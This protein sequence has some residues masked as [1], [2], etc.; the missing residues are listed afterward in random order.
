MKRILSTV[1]AVTAAMIVAGIIYS[2]FTPNPKSGPVNWLR[3][4]SAARS[5]A[6]DLQSHGQ[7]VPATVTLQDLMAEG[8]L[9]P[10]DVGGLSGMNAAVSLADETSPFLIR[11]QMQDGSGMSVL[12][13]GSVLAG[14]KVRLASDT[15]IANTMPLDPQQ[16]FK[17]H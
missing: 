7:P 11:V 12:K 16:G 9:T 2:S 4:S 8:L 14:G 10:Q 3:I 1:L 5:Y 15:V 6:L 17:L 13:D